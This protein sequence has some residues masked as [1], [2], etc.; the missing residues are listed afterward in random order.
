M[1]GLGGLNKSPEGVVIGLV[2]LQ[3]PVVVTR[4]DL[5]R[6][7]ERIVELVGKARRNLP[8][9]DLV[10]FP[11]YALHGLSHGHQPG[12]HV[13]ARRAGGR[14]FKQACVDNRI[15][16][17]F[18]IMELNPDGNPLQQRHHHR[19]HG[20]ASS[21]ITARCIPGCRSSR[22]SPAI[23]A[24]RCATDRTA[25]SS[26][27]SSATTA[28]FR[29]WRANAPTRAPTIMLRTAGYTAPIRH[30]GTSPTRPTHSAI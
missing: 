21:S 30:A 3:M 14:G 11:E 7:T 18:S 22:G 2:Q 23:S 15:W 5:A 8:T 1:S 17:C 27:S 12:D 16:G 26:R 13:H 29:R 28:C 6:Q 20:R 25:A 9:M 4:A 19:R 10:V 24:S